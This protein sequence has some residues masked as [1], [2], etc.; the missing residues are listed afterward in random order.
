MRTF[1][2]KNTEAAVP[3]AGRAEDLTSDRHRGAP[4]PAAVPFAPLLRST[5][6]GGAAAGNTYSVSVLMDFEMKRQRSVRS[7]PGLAG[8]DL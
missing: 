4:V 5:P 8:L 3:G 7:R 6:R 2:G 1:A